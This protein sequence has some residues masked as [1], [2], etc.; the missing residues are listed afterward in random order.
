MSKFEM[1][2]PCVV[3]PPPESAH[4]ARV[5]PLLGVPEAHVLLQ[6]GL[7]NRGVVAN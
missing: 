1:I 4:V 5:R 7:L 2:Q 3:F 6:G